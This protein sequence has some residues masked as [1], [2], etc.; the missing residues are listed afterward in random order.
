MALATKPLAGVRADFPVLE[1]EINGHPLVYLDS[2]AT[3]QKP[4][5][6]IETME[7]FYS[8]SYGTVHRGVYELGRRDPLTLRVDCGSVDPRHVEDVLQQAGQAV[9][10][11]QG[12]L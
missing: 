6:V 10:F 2:A 1:R 12:K 3:A 9:E 5:Q 7:R 11:V 8:H 4:R